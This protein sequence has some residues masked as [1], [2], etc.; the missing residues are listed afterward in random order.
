[1]PSWSDVREIVDGSDEQAQPSAT[2]IL[3]IA[4]PTHDGGDK[5]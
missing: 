3:N 4:L 2:C 5:F 1:M